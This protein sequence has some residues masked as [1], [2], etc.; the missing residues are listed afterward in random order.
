MTIGSILDICKM[1]LVDKRG[2]GP[3]GHIGRVFLTA[4]VELLERG[5]TVDD[6]VD[7]MTL[8]EGHGSDLIRKDNASHGKASSDARAVQ[9]EGKALM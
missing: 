9:P 6:D 1:N 3:S 7:P 8:M 5:F 2:V 4:S